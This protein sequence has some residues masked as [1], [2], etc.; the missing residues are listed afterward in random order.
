MGEVIE[1]KWRTALGCCLAAGVFAFPGPV[2]AIVADPRPRTCAAFSS[3]DIVL[4]GTVGP[5]RTNVFWHMWKVDVDR[6]YKGKAPDHFTLFSSADSASAT[7]DEGKRNILFIRRQGKR[8]MAW[9]SDPN[10]SGPD[11]AHVE[12]EVQQLAKT[13]PGKTGSVIGL[14]A[15]EDGEPRADWPVRLRRSDTGLIRTVRTDRAGKFSIDL[16][17]GK[18]SAKIVESGWSSRVSLYGYD[19]PDGFTLKAGGCAD[20]R[21]E[22]IKR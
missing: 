17:L 15:T 8:L 6:R 3:A 5:E 12:R 2:Q 9:G 7:P 20:L 11:A 21:L 4:T 18:W 14:V 19:N 10:T 16:P 1:R 22:P 13:K